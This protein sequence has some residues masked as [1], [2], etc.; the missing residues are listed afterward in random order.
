MRFAR[1]LEI[2]QRLKLRHGARVADFSAG[3]GYTT[4]EIARMVGAV[5]RVYAID[6]HPD[7]LSSLQHMARREGLENIRIICSDIEQPRGSLLKDDSV[8]AVVISNVYSRDHDRQRIE[9]EARRI[10]IPGGKMLCIDWEKGYGPT[11]SAVGSPKGFT[12]QEMF[13]L[14]KTHFGILAVK[15]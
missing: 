15:A 3:A 14:S 13:P 10:L 8:D 11:M 1:P 2:A 9:E 7:T 4:V 6:L 12:F 5:G